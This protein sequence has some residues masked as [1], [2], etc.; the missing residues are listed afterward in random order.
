[1]VESFDYSE[2]RVE[3]GE[4]E[5]RQ[6]D[7][8]SGA[9]RDGEE[10]D[11]RF[12]RGNLNYPR[13]GEV[14]GYDGAHSPTREIMRIRY[15]KIHLLLFIEDSRR[16]SRGRSRDSVRLY[17]GAGRQWFYPRFPAFGLR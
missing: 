6:I 7:D 11:E 13:S 16:M 12:S 2:K 1:M 5:R 3:V 4:I 10:F 14:F 8:Y 17:Q 15:D 9:W